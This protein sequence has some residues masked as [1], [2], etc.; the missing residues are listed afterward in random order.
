MSVILVDLGNEEH[1]EQVNWWNWRPTI[2]LIRSF[3]VIDDERLEMMG[4]NGSGVQVSEAEA[5]SIG[6]RMEREILPN[7]KS[8]DRI[9]LDLSVTAEP[10]DFRLHKDEDWVK[11]YSATHDWL[12]RFAGFC[13]TCCGFKV[14]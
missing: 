7:L 5:R 1:D 14:Y 2:E 12:A 8:K 11:N 10:K 9:L 13:K 4:C 3:A 6:I